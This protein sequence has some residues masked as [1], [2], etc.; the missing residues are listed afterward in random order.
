MITNRRYDRFWRAW[1]SVDPRQVFEETYAA[2][3]ERDI[4]NEIWER[5]ELTNPA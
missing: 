2:L 4:T 1:Q 3:V 5:A